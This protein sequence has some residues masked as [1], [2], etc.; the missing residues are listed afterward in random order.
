MLKKT[1]TRIIYYT[2]A[3]DSKEHI[4]IY[5]NGYHDNCKYYTGGHDDNCKYYTGDRKSKKPLPAAEV[6]FLLY[7]PA[8]KCFPPDHRCC[9]SAVIKDLC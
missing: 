5:Y 6:C 4:I 3:P 8:A 9:E 2:G 1:V 7:C